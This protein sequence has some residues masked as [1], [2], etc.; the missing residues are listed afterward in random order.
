[1]AALLAALERE[2]LAMGYRALWLETRR[3]NERALRFYRRHGYSEIPRYGAYVDR[4][5]A[6][7]LGKPLRAPVATASSPLHQESP[8]N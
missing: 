3:V 4:P 7:C 8:W 6:V 5:D 2:A 1:G